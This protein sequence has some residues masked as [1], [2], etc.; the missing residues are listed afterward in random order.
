VVSTGVDELEDAF[1]KT[2]I[3]VVADFLLDRDDSDPSLS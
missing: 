1:G 2:P 3:R